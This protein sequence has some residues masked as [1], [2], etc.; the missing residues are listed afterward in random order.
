MAPPL[1]GA[2]VRLRY[3]CVIRC[4]EVVKDAAGR[5]VELRCTADR[6]T[7]GGVAPEGRKVKGILHWV[8]AATALP[9]ELRLYDR[10]VRVE[11]PTA[12]DFLEELN[13]HSLE[14]CQGFVEPEIGATDSPAHWQFERQG[15]F[16]RDP[17][18]AAAGRLVFNR[19][20]GLREGWTAEAEKPAVAAPAPVERV[21]KPAEPHAAR[22]LPPEVEA[23]RA[24]LVARYAIADAAARV[25]AVEAGLAGLF[26]AA[27]A[28]APARRGPLR[29]QRGRGRA[30]AGQPPPKP[31][32]APPSAASS[33]SPKRA[34]SAR[35][36]PAGCWSCSSNAAATPMTS[37][38]PKASPAWTTPPPSPAGW[39]PRSP[40]TRELARYKAGQA[41]L[42]GFFVGKALKLSA[43][44]A[45]AA[46][47][48][49]AVIAAL[50]G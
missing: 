3:G 30:P 50:A 1:P 27:A 28:V 35:R 42:A 6:K 11:R 47:M 39:R 15:Y 19:T 20:V 17:V 44:R 33:R 48:Q 7:F 22:A 34:P 29:G 32:P 40:P 46:A 31:C 5:V 38:P 14:V 13:P 36:R 2:E 9:A 16:F 10:L 12:D 43:G 18:E 26:E 41:S 21:A 45:D 23:R 24:E 4:D 25:I 8:N 37:W 49:A